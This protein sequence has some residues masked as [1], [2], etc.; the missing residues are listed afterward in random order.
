M[1]HAP[2]QHYLIG[3]LAIGNNVSALG[4]FL[5]L[6]REL[7]RTRVRKMVAV[8]SAACFGMLLIFMF[9]GGAALDFFGISISAFQIAGGLLL[10]G[11]DLNMMNARQPT[12][13]DVKAVNHNLSEASN[14]AD[15][16]LYSGA[17][18]PIAIP[19]TVGAGTFSAVILYANV[20]NKTASSF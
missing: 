10:A 15:S 2:F 11:V 6:T 17:V 9:V 4:A 12:V 18:M 5:R 3:L 16:Q 13:V 14:Q 8:T 20:A 7:P 1:D 19:L